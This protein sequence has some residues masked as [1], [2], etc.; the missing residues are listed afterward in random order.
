MS[1]NAPANPALWAGNFICDDEVDNGRG[2]GDIRGGSSLGYG[3]PVKN[4]NL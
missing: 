2:I 3:A 1:G 4:R